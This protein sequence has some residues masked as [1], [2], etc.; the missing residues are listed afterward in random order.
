MRLHITPYCDAYASP[1]PVLFYC[2]RRLPVAC[3]PIYL[4]LYYHLHCSTTQVH[5]RWFDFWLRT[6]AMM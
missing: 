3:R 1:S 5:C 4:N 2:T 6:T